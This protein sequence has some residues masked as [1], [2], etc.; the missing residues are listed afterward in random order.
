MNL[1]IKLLN[2]RNKIKC[3]LSIKL[4]KNY[5]NENRIFQTLNFKKDLNT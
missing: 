5:Y 2:L 1:T 4:K 3:N